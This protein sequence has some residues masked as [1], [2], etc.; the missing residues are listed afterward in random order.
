MHTPEEAIEEL[1]FATGLGLKAFVFA[2]DVL[3]PIPE[4]EREHPELAHLAFYQDCFG[5][6]SP[7]DYDPVWAKCVELGVAPTFHSGPI[8]WGTHSSI[9]RHQYNQIGG[10]AQGGEAIA[11][12]LFFGGVTHRFP[13]L[14]FGFLE[15]GVSWAQSLYCRMLD[16]WKKRNGDAIQILDPARLDPDLLG[17]LDRPVRPRT[18]ARV[19]RSDREGLVVG[20]SSRRARRLER[21]RARAGG[22]DRRAVR[23]CVLLR[24]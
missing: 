3:R 8:G 5:I 10:F 11:K 12:A 9:S 4:V 20:R 23:A 18:S 6:D 21:V 2:G 14:R 19:P 13:T 16:H 1:E 17:E 24:V 7:H 22:A 15:A